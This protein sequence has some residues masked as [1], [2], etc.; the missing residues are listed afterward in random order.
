VLVKQVQYT[1]LVAVAVFMCLCGRGE[2][3]GVSGGRERAVVDGHDTFIWRER[4]S[5]RPGLLCALVALEGLDSPRL[6]LV[7]CCVRLPT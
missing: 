2:W 1:A 4:E 7:L 3:S 6:G 5:A